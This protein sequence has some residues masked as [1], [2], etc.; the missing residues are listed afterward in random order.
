MILSERT[1]NKTTNITRT[2]TLAHKCNLANANNARREREN[3][4]RKLENIWCSIVRYCCSRVSTTAH[5][6]S[7][8]MYTVHEQKYSYGSPE[9]ASMACTL[10]YS[11][12]FSGPFHFNFA[13]RLAAGIP[14]F[15]TKSFHITFDRPVN[16]ALLFVYGE[17][18]TACAMHT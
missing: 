4:E 12:S 8:S 2:Q 18:N 6:H 17:Y 1:R 16:V 5:M 13:L 10:F 11:P 15:G 9:Y 14:N 3:R 7:V